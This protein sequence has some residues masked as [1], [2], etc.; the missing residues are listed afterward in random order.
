[1][2]HA[3]CPGVAVHAADQAGGC[4]RRHGLTQQSK[5]VS[6][7]VRTHAVADST[8]FGDGTARS[9]PMPRCMVHV[10]CR[11]LY[12]VYCRFMVHG[13]WHMLHVACWLHVACCTR[14]SACCLLPRACCTLSFTGHM[15]HPIYRVF[16][17]CCTRLVVHDYVLCCPIRLARSVT[18][19]LP[20]LGADFA[21]S[22]VLDSMRRTGQKIFVCACLLRTQTRRTAHRAASSAGRCC[23]GHVGRARRSRV[24]RASFATCQRFALECAWAAR[25]GAVGCTER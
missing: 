1:M 8:L 16:V 17:A 10:A 24:V 25:S 14:S 18:I 12:A 20:A 6:A 4:Q 2:L 22:S 9:V 13:A 11:T 5:P 15:P 7:T 19:Q 23:R 3:A 21:H